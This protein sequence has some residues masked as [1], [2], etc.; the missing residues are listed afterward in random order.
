MSRPVKKEPGWFERIAINALLRRGYTI[1]ENHIVKKTEVDGGDILGGTKAR[2][3]ILAQKLKAV[4]EQ[5]EKKR[6]APEDMWESL[7]KRLRLL[8]Y[9]E[10]EG[11]TVVGIDGHTLGKLREFYISKDGRPFF[12]SAFGGANDI[13]GGESYEESFYEPAAPQPGMIY[14]SYK[15]NQ[16]GRIVFVKP[17]LYRPIMEPRDVLLSNA[18]LDPDKVIKVIDKYKVSAERANDGLNDFYQKASQLEKVTDVKIADLKRQIDSIGAMLNQLADV[19]PKNPPQKPE[20]K[21]GKDA[22]AAQ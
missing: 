20:K 15:R 16:D 4:T 11:K 21:N 22:D 1:K 19:R 8:R 17:Q 12:N 6:P 3:L 18:A 13:Y 5:P 9:P 14:V 2:N 10:L 7:K